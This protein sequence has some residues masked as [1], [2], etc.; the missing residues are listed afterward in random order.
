MIIQTITLK[1]IFGRYWGWHHFQ[2]I[3]DDNNNLIEYIYNG[4]DG[5]TK[6]EV[7]KIYRELKSYGEQ[8]EIEHTTKDITIDE[9]LKNLDN[10]IDKYVEYIDNGK[11]YREA[12]ESNRKI[13][14]RIKKYE[15]LKEK[16]V[17]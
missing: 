2:K 12:L 10:S 8:M 13:R 3:T 17:E 6:E 5:Y 16:G 1:G 11:Q 9:Y 15:A 14:E 7:D 4:K